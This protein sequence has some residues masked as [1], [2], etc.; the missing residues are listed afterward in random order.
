MPQPFRR[1]PL[2]RRVGGP[3]ERVSWHDAQVFLEA[4]NTEVPGLEARLPTEAQWEYAAR[5]GTETPRYGPLDEVAWYGDNSDW[6]THPVGTKAP[7]AW[8][9]YDMLGNVHEWC[10]DYLD[11]GGAYEAR[12]IPGTVIEDPGTV[13]EDPR[14]PGASRVIRGGDWFEVGEFSR[15]AFRNGALPEG[16]DSRLGLRL[17][18]GH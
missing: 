3:V 2:S 8:G 12:A 4:L 13:I 11:Y 16:R 6:T 5:A 17:S 18:R 10:Q 15:A 9:L 7:N 1:R 14:D